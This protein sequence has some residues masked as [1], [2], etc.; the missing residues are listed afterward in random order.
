[1][2][3]VD[4]KNLKQCI[5]KSCSPEQISYSNKFKVNLDKLTSLLADYNLIPIP[6]G[7]ASKPVV[8]EVI[9]FIS[10]YFEKK[11]L[12]WFSEEKQFT[13][14]TFVDAE[15]LSEYDIDKINNL[16][17][18]QTADPEYDKTHA[19]A[20]IVANYPCYFATVVSYKNNDPKNF[21]RLFY[22]IVCRANKV[23]I[24]SSDYQYNHR[25]MS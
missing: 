13:V 10:E 15:N 9:P 4:Y 18:D 14:L 11:R 6:V 16:A 19:M 12:L 21:G 2:Q 1:M 17:I 20:E 24:K 23:V 5:I 8:K 25:D 7:E 22:E 3:N